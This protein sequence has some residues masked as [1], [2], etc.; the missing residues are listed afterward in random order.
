MEI[1]N[2]FNLIRVVLSIFV[3][4]SH[5]YP[6]AGL[7]EP[8]YFY[9]SA[10]ML[11]VHGF[12]AISGYLITR[13]FERSPRVLSF[14]W[15]R[16]LRIAPGLV[17]AYLFS[18]FAYKAFDGYAGNPLVLLNASLWTLPWEML[19][20][21]AVGLVGVVGALNRNTFPALYCSLWFIFIMHLGDDG[22]LFY[23]VTAM[24]MMFLTG[25]FIALA[26]HRLSVPKAALAAVFVMLV[27]FTQTGIDALSALV[28]VADFAYGPKFPIGGIRQ[29]L[30]VAALSFIFIYLSVYAVRVPFFK[31]D[32]SYGV[33]VYAWPVQEI[34][35][36]LMA[37][38]GLAPGG[39]SVF[40]L[41]MP[42][43]VLLS[44]ISWRLIE[45]P[46]LGMKKLLAIRKT[47]VTHQIRS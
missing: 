38:H 12:F 31:D 47:Q 44:W 10:G 24:L 36:K 37:D 1:K 39:L 29:A 20:Y 15:N 34:V 17:V 46:A 25:A 28:K 7:P 2:N 27:V 30:Y 3:V 14:A 4:L 5:S 33:Y 23:F 40:L 32:I 35:V 21:V 13:S 45:K 26:E 9:M 16:L 8:T 18:K 41:S 22:R 11:A 6:V 42:P 43:I 19:C